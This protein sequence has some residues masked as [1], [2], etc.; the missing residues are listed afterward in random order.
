MFEKI[1]YSWET[2]FVKPGKAAFEKLLS[3]SGLKAEECIYVDNQESNIATA[4]SVG[5]K[6]I[7]FTDAEE[8][9]K[10]LKEYL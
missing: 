1:Y 9:E 6:A 10:N 7:L 8:L 5:V 4:K 2:G 3:D